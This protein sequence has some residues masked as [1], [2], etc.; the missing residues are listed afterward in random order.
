MVAFPYQII[1]MSIEWI[2]YKDL[3]KEAT[4]MAAKESKLNMSMVLDKYISAEENDYQNC[5]KIWP[6]RNP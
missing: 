1:K 3:M 5:C 2:M 6:F 4:I